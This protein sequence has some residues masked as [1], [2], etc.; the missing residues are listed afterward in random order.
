MFSDRSRFQANFNLPPHPKKYNLKKK[1]NSSAATN[2][3][4]RVV[5]RAS[6]L[7]LQQ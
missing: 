1:N 5:R 4:G 3:D 2:F 6:L 7:L